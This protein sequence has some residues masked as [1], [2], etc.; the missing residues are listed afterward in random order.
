MTFMNVQLKYKF[1]QMYI[2]TKIMELKQLG[3]LF[4]VSLRSLCY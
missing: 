2:I 4:V 1:N 3:L